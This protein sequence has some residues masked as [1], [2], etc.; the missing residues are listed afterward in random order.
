MERVQH[1]NKLEME[2]DPILPTDPAEGEWPTAGAVEFKDVELRYRP[3]LPLV[4]KGLTFTIEA[5]EK[6]GIIGR[7]GAG[8]SSLAQAIFR[9]VEICGGSISVD[10]RD[11]KELGLETVRWRVHAL[12]RHPLNA[13]FASASPLYPK[14]PSSS[15]AQS[16]E[17]SFAGQLSNRG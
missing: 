9:T 7:T 5:G 1:Y 8:K 3:E 17:Q 15:L 4:L 11:L 6:V 12:H 14:M 2:A 10:G 13:S 16:G